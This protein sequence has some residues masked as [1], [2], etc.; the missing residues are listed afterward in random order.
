M[1]ETQ[2]CARQVEQENI[3]KLAAEPYFVPG[4]D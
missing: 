1:P 3:F 4:A 2:N